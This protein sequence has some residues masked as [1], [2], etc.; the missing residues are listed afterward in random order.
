MDPDPGDT[1]SYRA[2]QR[3][4]AGRTDIELE[5][6]DF[7]GL[8]VHSSFAIEYGPAALPRFIAAG[9]GPGRD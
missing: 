4:G 7:E 9:A 2:H 8:S 6:S 3:G 1:L 5:A